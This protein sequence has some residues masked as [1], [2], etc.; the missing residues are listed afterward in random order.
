MQEALTHPEYGYYMHRDVFGARGDFVTSPEISQVF[1]E[2]VGVWCASTWEALGKPSKFSLVELG[3]GRGTLMSDLLR[4]TSKFKAFTAAMDVHMVEVSPKLRE[5]QREKLR[6]SGG[7]GGGGGGDAGAAAATSELNGRPVRWHDT[8]DAVP[9]GPIIVIAHEFFDAMPVHQF[10]RTERGWCEKLTEAAAAADDGALELVLSPGLT[11][12]GA[13]MIPRRLDGLP[14]ERKESIRQLEISPRSVAIWERVAGRLRVHPGAALAVDYGSE[15]P[16]G[17][18]LQAIKDHKFVDL[19]ADPG[20]ADLSAYVDFGA[21]RK[22]IEDGPSFARDGVRC[23]GPTT[24]RDLLG[25]LQIGARLERL[26]KECGSE[27]E[28][29]RLIEGC[30][31]LMAGDEGEGEGGS[32]DPGLG[33]RYKALAMV[34]KGVG[35]P[36][37]FVE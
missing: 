31:R 36:V 18:T 13:L 25:S 30:T 17:N 2:L 4:A 15:G 34:S 3:P 35:A 7:G 24:Q 37:G 22:V 9:E 5:M 20:T 16:T 12:A 33:I 1:G 19:L 10:T 8:F 32:A 26:V 6:C 23:Y 28:A 29:D 11:P 21:M 27:E 14:A